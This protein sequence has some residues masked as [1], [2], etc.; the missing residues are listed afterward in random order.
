MMIKAFKFE[1][2]P[3]NEFRWG[4][5]RELRWTLTTKD[6]NDKDIVVASN[7]ILPPDDFEPFIDHLFERTLHQFKEEIKKEKERRK[8]PDGPSKVV[9]AGDVPFLFRKKERPQ[10][11]DNVTLSEGICGKHDGGCSCCKKEKK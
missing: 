10:M 3:M 8:N 4:Y 7:Y 6:D 9:L 5:A 1:L 2:L 11:A